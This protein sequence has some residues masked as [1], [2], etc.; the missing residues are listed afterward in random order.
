MAFKNIVIVTL[1]ALKNGISFSQPENFLL[2]NGREVDSFYTTLIR[3]KDPKVEAD[4]DFKRFIIGKDSE[5]KNKIKLVFEVN[6]KIC[7]FSASHFYT[8]G[9][10][11]DSTI[12]IITQCY[13]D[14]VDEMKKYRI[15][16]LK[17]KYFIQIQPNKYVLKKP[18]KDDMSYSE[19]N[20]LNISNKHMIFQRKPSSDSPYVATHIYTTKLFTVN[21]IDKLLI[22][23]SKK[24]R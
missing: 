10:K 16:G 1:L 12:H 6:K 18:L 22:S 11:I 5:G 23:I 21:E 9:G 14:E 19:Y 20:N 3:Y 17:E 2:L 4:F 24:K 15:G 13:K 8:E 7:S